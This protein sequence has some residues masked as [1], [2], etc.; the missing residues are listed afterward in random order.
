M[1]TVKEWIET[2]EARC[3]EKVEKLVIGL[4]PDW[5]D[6]DYVTLPP[7]PWHNTPLNREEGLAHLT[8]DFYP[9]F[10][11]PAS[12]PIYAWTPTYLFLIHEYDGATSLRILPRNPIGCAPDFGGWAEW[13]DNP[14]PRKEAK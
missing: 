4:G 7:A 9:G 5:H 14:L 11:S 3:G 2:A 6:E 13:S 12:P 10:G 1:A 8:A